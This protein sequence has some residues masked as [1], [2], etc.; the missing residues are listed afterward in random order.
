MVFLIMWESTAEA[1]QGVPMWPKQRVVRMDSISAAVSLV[2]QL[3]R[4]TAV[5]NTSTWNWSYNLRPQNAVSWISLGGFMYLR[6]MFIKGSLWPRRVIPGPGCSM[7][8]GR[9]QES[10][11]QSNP[12]MPQHVARH[13]VCAFPLSV[14]ELSA[15]WK[16]LQN[17]V[18]NLRIQNLLLERQRRDY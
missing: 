5:M 11:V 9:Q 14:M 4:L 3:W 12:P 6:E 18:R 2:P 13:M 15:L 17:F 7:G 10:A 16:S 1:L 8:R